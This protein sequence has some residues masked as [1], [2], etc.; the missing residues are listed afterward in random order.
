MGANLS[1]PFPK[2]GRRKG[3]PRLVDKKGEV[4]ARRRVEHEP[5]L[6]QDRNIN[7]RPRLVLLERKNA[8]TNVLTAYPHAKFDVT[9]HGLLLKP[10]AP[11]VP[12]TTVKG[13]SL[14]EA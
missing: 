7:L 1:E 5:Q 2:P 9:P 12:K 4:V 3:L 14:I 11:A 10:S 13:F 8:V 6:R